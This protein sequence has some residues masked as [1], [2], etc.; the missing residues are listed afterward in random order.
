MADIELVEKQLQAL[1]D[2]VDVRFETYAASY[3]TIK[4]LEGSIGNIKEL[5]EQVARRI[6]GE[7]RSL[8]LRLDNKDRSDAVALN[9]AK[10][11]VNVAMAASEKAVTKAEAASEKRFESVNEF[12]AQ[13]A[14]MQQTFARS[15]NVAIQFAAVQKKADEN[16]A[17]LLEFRTSVMAR[18]TGYANVWGW[19]MGALVA[20]SALTG[21]LFSLFK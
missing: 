1:W 16:A 10:E 13:M 4:M 2:R 18:N 8:H 14:D 17:V 11:A 7:I 20:G 21:A 15:D 3:V 12:R 19:A 6:E 9:A 5:I